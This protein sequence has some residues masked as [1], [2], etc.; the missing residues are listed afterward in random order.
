MVTLA[1]FAGLSFYISIGFAYAGFL[2]GHNPASS[3]K[4]VL[5]VL[6]PLVMTLHIFNTMCGAA[7]T[8]GAT[9]AGWKK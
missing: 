1:Y 4:I 8:F 3:S 5:G 9:L 6:W 2:E 7:V